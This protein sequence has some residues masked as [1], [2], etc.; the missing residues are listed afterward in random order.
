MTATRKPLTAVAAARM[1]KA[2]ASTALSRDA[3]VGISG[4]SKPVVTRYLNELYTAVPKLVHVGQWGA[5]PRGYAT[6]RM[7][8]WGDKPDAP[9][10]GKWA[11]DAERMRAA[12]KAGAA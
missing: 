4:L 5:D 11:S 6:I 8:R 1:Q 12:R 2:M 7:F 3:L 9:K 10:P